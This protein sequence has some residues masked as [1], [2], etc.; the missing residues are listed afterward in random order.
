M[1][2]RADNAPSPQPRQTP[3]GGAIAWWENALLQG[4]L[5]SLCLHLLLG[6]SAAWF[7]LNA[8]PPGGLAEN[9]TIELAST[10]GSTLTELTAIPLPAAETSVESA[11]H[12]QQ[13]DITDLTSPFS[14]SN[15]PG[16][17]LGA[18]DN[19][20]GAGTGGAGSGTGDG[21]GGAGGE[22]R[23]FGVEAR[24]SRFAFV[25]DVSGSM[26][27]P[28]KIG[29]L[30][31]ALIESIEGM[32]DS[33]HFYVVRYSDAAS[34]LLGSTWSRASDDNKTAAKRN[35]MQI[36]PMGSTN[37]LPAFENIFR[38][39]PLPDAV[40][41]MTDGVF[42]EQ[43]ENELPIFIEQNNRAQDARIA[44]HCITFTDRGAEKL[45][46]RIA[47]QSGGSYTHVEAPKK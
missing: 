34:P 13:F 23:F 2:P 41:F 31:A 46:R 10:E 26:Q 38:L 12:E 5:F 24:G 15:Q 7:H 17:G 6:V 4:L 35:I 29:A 42:S 11:P 18:L 33:A 25:I 40:Y 30:R 16:G 39:R 8:K 14:D 1:T 44:I 37:P 32:L 19:L 20:G 47:R 3:A 36:N 9:P 28:S 22:A 27:E 21:L 43:V 45:M